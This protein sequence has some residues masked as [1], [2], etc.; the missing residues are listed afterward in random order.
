VGVLVDGE[1]EFANFGVT[2]VENPLPVDQETLFQAGSITKTLTATALAR[3][4]QAGRIELDA[5]VR[6][7]LPDLRLADEDVAAAITTRDLLT[8][9][10][11]FAGDLFDDLGW[12]A[13]AIERIVARAAEL[14]QLTPLGTVWSYNNAGFYVAGLVLEVVTEK[15]YEEAVRELVL[16]GALFEPWE[17]MTRRFAVGHLTEDDEVRVARPWPVPRTAVAAGGWVTSVSELLRYGR[18]HLEDAT[19]AGLQ[20][21]VLTAQPG[22]SMGLAWFVKDRG[23]VRVVEHGGTT[24]GQCARLSLGPEHGFAIA[25]LTNHALGHAVIGPVLDQA[26]SDYLG[27]APWEPSERDLPRATLADYA[28]AYDAR[29]TTIHLELE[30]DALILRIE[31]KAGFPKPDSPPLPA[32][33]PAPVAFEAEDALYVADGPMRH[34]RGQFLRD[35]DGEIEWLRFGLR[36]HRRR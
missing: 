9:A 14:E 6:T 27:V 22:E 17:V 24:L 5:P 21:P 19:L 12:G 3:L 16:P 26:F 20:E 25:V 7:Y 33:P 4:E 13:D 31:S 35:A 15:P 11:G 28:G 34:Q 8:H 36:I 23:G 10:G 18:M 30:D 2:S 29:A 1:Q 32:P